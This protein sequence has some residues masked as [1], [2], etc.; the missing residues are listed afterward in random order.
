MQLHLDPEQPQQV[1]FRILMDS[2]QPYMSQAL[3]ALFHHPGEPL[4]N[5]GKFLKRTSGQ[6]AIGLTA[7][8]AAGGA[9]SAAALWKVGLRLPRSLGYRLGFLSMPLATP[10]VGGFIGLALGAGGA[11]LLIGQLRKA[12]LLRLATLHAQVS[13]VMLYADGVDAAFRERV[14]EELKDR[15]VGSGLKPDVVESLFVHAPLRVESLDLDLDAYEPATLAAVVTAVWQLLHAEGEIPAAM[16]HTFLR[17]CRRLNLGDDFARLKQQAQAALEEQSA[18]IGAAI[19]AARHLGSDFHIATIEQ[20]LEQLIALDPIA[21]AR[22]KRRKTLHVT[23]D[24]VATASAIA[25]VAV[26]RSQ[27][28]PIIGHAYA[29][30]HAAVSG[31]ETES[32]RL[33]ARALE[34]LKQLGV[35]PEDANRFLP[36]IIETLDA[37]RSTPRPRNEVVA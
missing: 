33:Q 10:V 23:T 22:E 11:A 13:S 18:R 20:S 3:G 15:L 6:L 25:A 21:S 17:L 14:L 4:K 2:V 19:E 26:G 36:P 5:L 27:L 24:V 8:G 7:A 12:E 32:K 9:T 28:L 16:E 37:L 34:L 1:M 35:K 29:V 30:L 31:D